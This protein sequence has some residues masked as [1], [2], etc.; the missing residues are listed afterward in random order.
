MS[1]VA[2]RLGA[3]A[4]VLSMLP[5]TRQKLLLG[6]TCA[7]LMIPVSL[8]RPLDLDLRIHRWALGLLTCT[9]RVGCVDRMCAIGLGSMPRP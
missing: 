7:R 9:L 2:L 6:S 8:L 1:R 3:L 4:R 5:I